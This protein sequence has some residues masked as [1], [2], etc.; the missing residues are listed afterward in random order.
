MAFYASKKDDDAVVDSTDV[1]HEGTAGR[2]SSL[3]PPS[4]ASSSS[5]GNFGANA[6]GGHAHQNG[7]RSSDDGPSPTGPAAASVTS[8]T[9]PSCRPQS[10]SPPPITMTLPSKWEPYRVLF[11]LALN[12]VSSIGIVWANKYIFQY[13]HFRFGT[14]LTWLHFVATYIGLELCRG[15]EGL[16]FQGFRWLRGK[17][18]GGGAAAVT[19]RR[20][21]SFTSPK[22][23]VTLDLVTPGGVG[24]PNIS[25]NSSASTS[26]C[27]WCTPLY[28]F[29]TLPISAV[30]PLVYSF[31]GF[32]VLTNLSL[33]Y[34][35]VSFYQVM[36][37]LTAPLI[38]V[39]ERIWFN[40]RYPWSILLALT[41]TC[42]GVTVTT[43]SDTEATI[44]GT[45]IALSA[46]WVTSWYQIWVQKKQKELQC[47]GFQLLYYQSSLSL[48]LIAFLWLITKGW[49]FGES[50]QDI[51]DWV[52]YGVLTWPQ[53]VDPSKVGARDFGIGPLH[54]EGVDSNF[55]PGLDHQ[56]RMDLRSS[57]KILSPITITRTLRQ[58]PHEYW[59]LMGWILL[60]CIFAFLVN[61]STFLVIGK[62]SPMTYNVL[63]HFKLVTITSLGFMFFGSPL[64]WK[65]GMGVM[66]TVSGMVAYTTLKQKGG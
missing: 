32:V 29:K 41:V 3:A 9:G 37:V 39:I 13:H 10:N 22:S 30:F 28:T 60:S 61:L 1:E 47:N 2:M 21:P 26:S 24:S 5:G 11:Y 35:S 64:T 31:C 12:V 51:W 59:S 40:Q 56:T 18:F 36:K 7:F 54:R 46:L 16:L 58:T 27:T 25:S 6:D 34:N 48:L 55:E 62:T 42:I 50:M 52:R 15:G 49:I 4:L 44:K 17:I 53:V 23:P 19:H 57:S 63:G 45:L 65:I 33:L 66:L 43:I 8:T 38:V 14:L 20:G